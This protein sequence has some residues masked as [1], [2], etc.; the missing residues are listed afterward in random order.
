[1]AC[2]CELVVA[3]S[4]GELRLGARLNFDPNPLDRRSFQGGPLRFLFPPLS[5]RFLSGGL[6]RLSPARFFAAR[7]RRAL[8]AGSLGR[9]SFFVLRRAFRGEP[10]SLDVFELAE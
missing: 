8:G 10:L 7:L 9:E 1:M 4:L 5:R 3:T 2:E 6:G